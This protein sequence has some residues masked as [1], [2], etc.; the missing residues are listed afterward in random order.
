MKSISISD[1]AKLAF[2]F[3][4]LLTAIAIPQTQAQTFK[5]VYSFSGASDGGNP[6]DGLVADTSGN[7]YS[8][9]S[10]GGAS[11]N[12]AVIEFS[13]TGVESVL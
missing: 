11:G 1:S 8:T 10:A 7:L 12:G 5:V 9:T 3:A 13:K 4:L 2:A 6:L